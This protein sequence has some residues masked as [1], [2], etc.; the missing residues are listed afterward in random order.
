MQ[1]YALALIL[2]LVVPASAATRLN[3]AI[4]ADVNVVEVHKTLLGPGFRATVPDVE[5]NVVGTGTGEPA[6]RAIYTKIKAQADAGRKPWDHRR[7]AGEHGRRLPDG[8]GGLA[9]PLRPADEERGA[10]QGRRG[11]GG[12]RRL[13]RRLRRADVPQPDR[14]RL[15][16]VEGPESTQVVRRARRMGQGQSRALRLQRHQG[17]RERRRLH[18]GLGVLED[19]PVQGADRRGPST[20]RRSRPSARPSP[21]SA[22]STNRRSSRTATRARSTR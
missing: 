15:S 6:S 3:V 10:G 16:P 14:D 1:L 20:R 11:E 19:R 8:E 4:G 7:G 21:R 12:V 9:P 22:T 2:A 13:R 17:R 18:D 5:L